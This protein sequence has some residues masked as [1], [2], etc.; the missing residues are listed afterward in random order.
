MKGKDVSLWLKILGCVFVIAMTVLKATLS[1]EIRV[2][3]IVFVGVFI[4][5]T[6]APVD[7]SKIITNARGGANGKAV[8]SEQ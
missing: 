3:E 5:A 2:E 1:W 7:I 6:G 4:A 8:Q